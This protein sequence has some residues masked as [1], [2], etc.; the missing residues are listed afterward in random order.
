MNSSSEEQ[1]QDNIRRIV[2][3]E[4]AVQE[5]GK[6]WYRHAL[7]IITALALL[8][9]ISSAVFT[10]VGKNADEI[11][12]KKEELRKLISD[13]LDLKYSDDA[14]ND[15][16]RFTKIGLYIDAAEFLVNQIPDKVS[17]YEYMVI[18]DQ[19]DSIVDYR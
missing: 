16:S 8:V 19:M 11:R 13:V 6:P 1:Q 18:A 3:L 7:T 9:S 2:L 4:S 15:L 5:L 14:K 10:Y 17:S 12:L